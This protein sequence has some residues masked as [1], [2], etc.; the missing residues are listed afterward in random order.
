[1]TKRYLI[2]GEIIP[3]DEA[4]LH[5]S[6]LSITRGYGIFDFFRTSS[7]KPLFMD[8]HLI[9]FRNSAKVLGLSLDYD[10]EIIKSWIIKLIELNGFKESS[11]K[12]VLTGGYSPGGYEPI[13]PNFIIMLDECHFPPM[14][15]YENGV[16]L[17]TQDHLRE[18][19]EVKSIN[20]LTAV[21]SIRRCKEEGAADVLYH[22]GEMV[23]EVT[24]SNFFL[25]KSGKI[26]TP[27]EKILLGITRKHVLELAE[28]HYTVEVRDVRLSE[29]YEADETFITS[30]TQTYSHPA[31][32]AR[33]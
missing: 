32:T 24:R 2:N 14:C 31:R 15:D 16:K 12:M 8:H 25:V 29:I 21:Q 27:S 1:M 13:S 4:K 18:F 30:S 26:I 3:S 6:D 33:L 23:L 5:V 9:R 10:D 28:K 11:V 22:D 20:Y 19:P 17:I 7:G